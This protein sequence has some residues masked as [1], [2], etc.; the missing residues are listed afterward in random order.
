M[1]TRCE[2]YKHVSHWAYSRYECFVINIQSR[3]NLLSITN[4]KDNVPIENNYCL[5][6]ELSDS[7]NIWSRRCAPLPN[8]NCLRL[9]H[10]PYRSLY[11]I[12]YL[13]ISSVFLVAYIKQL[14]KLLL[15]F[16]KHYFT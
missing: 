13:I 11:L 14:C 2:G 7:D 12:Y 3:K 4:V 16:S 5:E 1:A 8:N 9:V 15:L 10:C 6:E